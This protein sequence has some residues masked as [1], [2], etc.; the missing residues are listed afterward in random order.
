MLVV[1]GKGVFSEVVDSVIKFGEVPQFQILLISFGYLVHH[2]QVTAVRWDHR[3][4][5]LGAHYDLL[6][7][8]MLLQ[9]LLVHAATSTPLYRFDFSSQHPSEAD[10][11][12]LQV[13]LVAEVLHPLY[14]H[15]FQV[16]IVLS[17]HRTCLSKIVYW[18]N[19][20]EKSISLL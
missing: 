1:L 12:H 3:V 4:L 6:Q 15:T 17:R 5:Q 11:S 18:E 20:L 19:T 8:L 2:G 14:R 16:R 10:A 7:I 13:S 9:L